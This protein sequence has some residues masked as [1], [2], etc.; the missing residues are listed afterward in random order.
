M[1][2]T[3]KEFV[4]ERCDKLL[5]NIYFADCNLYGKQY[6]T[7]SVS[8]VRVSHVFDKD[9]HQILG[10]Q[11]LRR[12][13]DDHTLNLREVVLNTSYGPSW[14]THWFYVEIVV[15]VHMA[16]QPLQF[17][18]DCGAEAL[19]YRDGKA[20]Q[21]LTGGSGD[22]VNRNTVVISTEGLE[23]GSQILLFIEVSCNALHGMGSPTMISPPATDRHFQLKQA[24]ALETAIYDYH[25]TTLFYFFVS[26][27]C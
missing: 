22:D 4:V 13:I 3:E 9:P 1:P 21:G 18:F 24:G 25:V 27:V 26:I 7:R 14:A 6:V 15:P 20:I 2:F 11:A 10:F 16:Q 23:E 17:H 5:S 19:V 12:A 8:C